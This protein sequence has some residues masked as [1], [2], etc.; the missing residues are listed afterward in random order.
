MGDMAR[1]KD[2]AQRRQEIV[3]AT[4][5]AIV[6][7]GLGGLRIKDVADEAGLSPGLV[8]YYYADFEDLLAEVHQDA[9]DRFYWARLRAVEAAGSPA[10]QLRAL[11]RHGVPDDGDD[12]LCRVLYELHVHAARSRTHAVLM[13]ALYDREV[14]LYLGVLRAGQSQGVFDLT[15]ESD[16]IAASAVALEDAYGLHIVGRNAH[17]SA[18]F[19]RE[20]ILAY[21]RGA[22]G[23]DLD[24][25]PED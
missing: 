8:S 7:R 16:G 17:V 5:R 22:T 12:Q 18:G 6:A 15:D 24:D 3:R 4:A 19:A 1:P 21:L 9:V 25:E 23:A 14:S 2:Q 20:R 13:T 10:A 11:V